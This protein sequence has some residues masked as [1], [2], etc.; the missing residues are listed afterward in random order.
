MNPQEPSNDKSEPAV[1]RG[2]LMSAAEASD[3]DN[4]T[5]IVESG[6]RTEDGR[7]VGGT[8]DEPQVEEPEL[9]TIADSIDAVDEPQVEEPVITMED[10][11]DFQPKDYSFEVTVFD[12]EG[13][14]GKQVKI[15][16]PEAWDE[17]LET[18]PNLGSAAAL[19]KGLRLA[20]KME[21]NLDRDKADFDTL[22]ETFTKHTQEAESRV[23]ATNNMVA[24]I[25][26]LIESK[27]LPTIDPK[28]K[29]ADWTNPE[30]AKQPGIKEQVA[31]L[32]FMRDENNRRTR[33][34]LK[35][36]TSVLDAFNAYERANSKTQQIS[37][38]KLAGEQRKA[39]GAIV[40]PASPSAQTAAPK[41]ISVGR[42][43][44]LRDLGANGW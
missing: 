37:A 29:D 12:A 10:P 31:L 28:Y 1:P 30:V 9:S 18:D 24:E 3:W 7:T 43:G 4:D 25:N 15:S 40:A 5:R 6:A 35:P 21:T 23:A 22:K 2:K 17:L 32:T 36:M 26:Y 13:K 19:A 34:G 8:P 33:L 20:S 14:A 42:G 27:E 44:S 38:Q 11:G 41:G 16:S 39:A